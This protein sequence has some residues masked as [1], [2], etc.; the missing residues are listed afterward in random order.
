MPLVVY[1]DETGDHSLELIDHNYPVFGIVMVVCDTERYVNEI[2]PR[3]CKL[4]FDFF[5]HEGVILHSRDIRR[6]QGEFGFLTDPGMR[7]PFYERIN[8]VMANCD[9]QL[10]AAFIKKQRHKDRY[11]DWALHPYDLALTFALE[12]LLPLLEAAG[13]QSVRLIAESRGQ[14]EDNDL[15]LSF[16][17]V[18]NGGTDYISV[19]RFGKIRFELEFRPKRSNLVGHQ[20]A[21]LAAY[22]IARRVIDPRKEN[23]AFE[24]VKPKFY[25]G[26]GNVYG[27][28]T[29]P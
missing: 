9:Y 2:V 21:D 10:I 23:L 26:P 4:K 29:F 6:A 5:G 14:N 19:D 17:K 24:V 12:R 15:H 25:R 11:G 28:K 18:V 3:V 7:P 27:L 1:L 8:D 13:Q 16:L 22:P 20:V